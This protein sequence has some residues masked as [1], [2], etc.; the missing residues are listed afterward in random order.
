ME[1]VHIYHTNDIHSH[2][3]NWPRIQAYLTTEQKRHQLLNDNV[4]TFDIGDACDRVH[5]LT[6]ATDGKA[7]IQMLNE[8]HYEAVTIGNNEGIG[9]S[10][11]QL[12]QLYQ[13]ANFSVLLANL[14]DH[15]TGEAPD[16]AL[17]FQLYETNAGHRIGVFGLT[18]PFPTSYGPLGWK[19]QEPD[20]CLPEILELLSPL[21]DTI[22]LL[23]HL[24][25]IEDRRIAE[26]Y[27]MI[28]LII[29]SHTHHLLPVG[30]QVRQ[31]F[32]TAAG[33]FGLYVGHI[34][35]EIKDSQLSKVSASVVET[36]TLPVAPNEE[37][38]ITSYQVEGHRLLA[39]Q[40]IAEIPH[41]FSVRWIGSSPLV[42]L[43]LK[44]LKDYANTDVA[45]LNAGLFMEPL[46]KG[47]ISNDNL[48]NILPH[49]MRGMTC[50]MD[51]ANLY[52]V[53][54]EMEKNRGY[55]RNFAIKGMGFRGEVFGEICYDGV[56]YQPE[57]DRVLWLGEP[58]DFEKQYT[59][60]TVDHFLYIPFFPTI[61]IISQNQVIFPY[62]IRNVLGQYLTRNYPIQ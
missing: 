30:E 25:I 50:T 17:P 39:Q 45:I 40:K 53:I 41:D 13:E 8:G 23:S 36:A 21:A 22:I 16:W 38:Q 47:I 46:P 57:L 4:L 49:P 9:N 26:M 43:G 54:R 3:E 61:E 2:F 56:S 11:K 59:F 60:A 35:L 44:A 27:P 42:E 52:R 33:K 14:L 51:G 6:E 48:H 29:G 31:T 24:G 32:I 1:Q 19:V 37:Q 7:N 10:K 15:Q 5:P 28:D 34:I 18:A 55:L 20:D 12:N 58:I 62:F